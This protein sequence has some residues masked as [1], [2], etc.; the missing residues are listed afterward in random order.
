MKR[1]WLLCLLAAP[2][3]AQTYK[4]LKYP[5]IGT[6]KIPDVTQVTLPNGMRVYLLEDH[7]I[8]LVRGLA[9]VRT[10]NLFDPAD[11]VGLATMTGMVLRTGGTKSKTGDQLD[12]QLENVA[13]SVETNIGESL[14]TVSFSALTGNTGEVLAV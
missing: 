9:L 7:T 2:L 11:K 1:L 8:P 4:D 13:A 14:G 5:S 10:G 3:P 6:I 12:E